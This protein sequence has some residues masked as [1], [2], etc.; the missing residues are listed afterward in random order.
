MLM[1]GYAKEYRINGDSTMSVKVRIPAIHGPYKQSQAM[2]QTI[3][4]YVSDDAL[5]WYPSI[6]LPYNPSD[7]DVVVLSTTN[8]TVNSWIVI[9]VTGGSYNTGLSNIQGG[10]GNG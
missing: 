5:P 3:R 4:N 7:G 6:L 1:Y 8:D 2:G 9:G 10:I